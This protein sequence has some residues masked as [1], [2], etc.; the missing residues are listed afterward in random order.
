MDECKPLL[1]GGGGGGCAGVGAAQGRS[2]TRGG[3]R[4]GAAPRGAGH[5]AH[6]QGGARRCRGQ[7]R[8]GG[9]AGQIISASYSPSPSPSSSSSSSSFSS[10]TSSS[11]SSP[12]CSPSSSSSSSSSSSYHVSLNPCARC[13]GHGCRVALLLLCAQ[14]DHERHLSA[15]GQPRQRR[16]DRSRR[17]GGDP[18]RGYWE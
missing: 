11:S 3:H 17:I 16:V 4:A 8:A 2:D 6:G 7:G 13:G 1:G 5:G 12:S 18:T 15:Q 14:G 10:A 9:G